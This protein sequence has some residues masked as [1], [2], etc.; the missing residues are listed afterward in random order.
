MVCT[1]LTCPHR[2]TR[3]NLVISHLRFRIRR[4][5]HLCTP[6]LWGSPQWYFTPA[7][8]LT[9]RKWLMKAKIVAEALLRYDTLRYGMI[10]NGLGSSIFMKKQKQILERVFE[11]L[12]HILLNKVLLITPF[13]IKNGILLNGCLS[14]SLIVQ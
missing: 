6:P 8:Q 10:T 5:V 14:P 11:L 3:W 1:V 9:L 7:A 2:T 12:V 4:S 13:K